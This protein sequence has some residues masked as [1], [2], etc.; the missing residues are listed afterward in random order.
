MIASYKQNL[1]QLGEQMKFPK[2]L[3]N[4]SEFPENANRTG[5]FTWPDG[6]TYVGE[7]KNGHPHGF[8][9]YTWPDGDKYVGFWFCGKRHGLGFHSRRNGFVY[10]GN[11]V[12][13]I[14]QGDGASIDEQ[15]NSYSGE[16]KSGIQNG[17]GAVR[18]SVEGLMFYGEWNNGRPVF[19]EKTKLSQKC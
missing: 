11:F 15:G 7:Y 14:P 2:K 10:V 12:D 17:R 13:N 1:C 18:G 8:G 4:Y 6:S 3:D 16:W 19:Y 9:T 5:N